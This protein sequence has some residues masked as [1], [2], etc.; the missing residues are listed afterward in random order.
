MFPIKVTNNL[1]LCWRQNL[2]T[3]LC[4]FSS[5]SSITH[6]SVNILFHHLFILTRG[7]SAGGKISITRGP[8]FRS[9]D[10]ASRGNWL[11][12]LRLKALS[13]S[14]STAWIFLTLMMQRASF[15]GKQKLFRQVHVKNN[16]QRLSEVLMI[17]IMLCLTVHYF[18]KIILS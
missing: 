16:K 11:T 7:N 18:T 9:D 14:F 4:S 5:V 17:Y 2:E 15:P 3:T 10:W 6:R 12:F 8:H 13:S 1:F